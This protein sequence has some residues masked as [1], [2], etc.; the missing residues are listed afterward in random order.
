MIYTISQVTVKNNTSF[1]D[2]PIILYR[3][4]KNVE[5]Q[6]VLVDRT[7]LQ[8][9]VEESNIIEDLEADK[10]QLII[11]KPDGA[12]EESDIVNTKNGKVVFTVPEAMIDESSEVGT[13]TFQ[14]RLFNEDLTSRVTLPPCVDGLVIEE[15]IA[16]Y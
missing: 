15:P 2:R 1:L 8:Y 12:V 5:I 13:F 7:F 9:K 16:G 6:F 3:G 11:M 4:D 14:I 10:G